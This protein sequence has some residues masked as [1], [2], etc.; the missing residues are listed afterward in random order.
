VIRAIVFALIA[1]YLAFAPVWAKAEGRVPEGPTET[2]LSF[3]PV[4]RANSAAVVIIYVRRI[5]LE[6]RSPFNDD[7]L[8]GDL[9]HYFGK[10][11][12]RA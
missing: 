8:F 3:V 7:P 1:V 5:V 11:A 4:V 2:L 12:L 10:L 9:F 6:R